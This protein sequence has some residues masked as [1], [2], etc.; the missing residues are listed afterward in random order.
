KKLVGGG[1]MSFVNQTVPRALRRLGYSPDQIAD[2]LA[3]VDAHNSILG[4]R[5][6]HPAHLSVFAC[7]MGD[8]VIHYEGHVRMMGSGQPFISGS[9]SKRAN[10]PEDVTI[11][12]V[13]ALHMLAWKLGL[14]A[15][16]IYRDNCKVGQP[17]SAA[18]VSQP[19]E[20]VTKVI[21]RVIESHTPVRERL[22]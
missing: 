11:D 14:K 20:T 6:V 1:T 2:I 18:P 15:I 12:D 13:E 22:P 3:Y 16:A 10:M 5:H 19:A 9:I 17:L 7:S 21:E 8:N 4:A